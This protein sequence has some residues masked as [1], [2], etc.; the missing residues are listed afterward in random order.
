[1]KSGGRFRFLEPK[2]APGPEGG[3]IRARDW[4][5]T[6]CTAGALLGRRAMAKGMLGCGP[7][8]TFIL[9]ELMLALCLSL[10]GTETPP[11]PGGS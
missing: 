4:L 8:G 1:M 6:G 10:L 7:V 5:A 2:K 3:S 11:P 9:S